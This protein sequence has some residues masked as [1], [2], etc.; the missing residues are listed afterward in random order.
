MAIPSTTQEMLRCYMQLNE[1]EQQSV[2][3]L[4]KTF[5]ATRKELSKAVTPEDY[6]YELELAEAEMKA[7]G[8]ILHN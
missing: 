1:A 6:Y 2:L 4:I 7:R 3:Q 8:Y 5:Q